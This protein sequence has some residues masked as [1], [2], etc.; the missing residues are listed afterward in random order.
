MIA[1]PI[2]ERSPLEVHLLQVTKDTKVIHHKG[3][4]RDS[5]QR[6]CS[7]QRI[8]RAQRTQ[9]KTAMLPNE[10]SHAA[11]RA[12]IKVH[13]AIGPGAL[14]S[15]YDACMFYELRNTGLHVEHQVRLPLVYGEIQLPVAD[16]V[17]FIVENCLILEIKCV[18]KLL[19]VHRAQVLS[20]TTVQPPS[21]DGVLCGRPLC[22]PLC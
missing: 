10:T 19:P 7:S 4:Q 22:G 12:A 6:T 3:P 5:S 14:E 17:D 8:Q 9:R 18:Q 21:C 1:H 2:E 16:R 11:I 13:T 20:Y 15:T